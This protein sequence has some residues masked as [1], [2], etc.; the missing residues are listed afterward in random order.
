MQRVVGEG[1][2]QALL[3]E[4]FELSD[5]LQ[6][7]ETLYAIAYAQVEDILGGADGRATVTG[8]LSLEAYHT[9]DMPGR[10]LVYT[11]HAM[12]FEQTVGL[13]GALGDALV[14][15]STV[16]DVA[17]LSREGDGGSKLMRAEVQLHTELAAVRGEEITALRDVFTTRGPGME[18][19]TQQVLFRAGTVN[20]QTAESGRTVMMLPEGSPRVK[21]PFLAFARPILI[22]S[23]R[24]NGK[25]AVDGIL[26]AT[27]IYQTDD[28]NVP[29]SIQ[30]EEPF[31]ALFSTEA[32]PDDMLSLS[33]SQA[34]ASAIT[35]DRVEIKY[36]LHLNAEGVRKADARVIL[37]AAAVDVPPAEKGIALYFLQE[38]ER[39]WDI[40]KRYRIPLPEL[41]ELNPNLTEEPV[42]GTPVIA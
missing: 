26:D 6:I 17:V 4:E 10:A 37:D 5:V 34:E 30:Q 12:P 42:A 20:D 27:L 36:I 39:M 25:L 13:S 8:T 31:H 32:L 41:L 15:R 23:E 3:R 2:N 24:Q 11:R 7:K 28:S 14:A 40:A 16:R 38:G 1:E 19:R 18:V 22:K 21:T 29:V 9:S 33:V 35:G